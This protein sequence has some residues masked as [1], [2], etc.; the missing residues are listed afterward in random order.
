M[1]TPTNNPADPEETRPQLGE[2][3]RLILEERRASGQPGYAV[4]SLTP[5]TSRYRVDGVLLWLFVLL[6]ASWVIG[7]FALLAGGG[8]TVGQMLLGLACIA[9]GGLCLGLSYGMRRA[10]P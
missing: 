7:G 3:A 2:Q 10:S 8:W 5:P 9:H 4:P 6:G 1:N